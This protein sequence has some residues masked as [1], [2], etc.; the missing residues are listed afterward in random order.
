MPYDETRRVLLCDVLEGGRGRRFSLDEKADDGG[1][2]D[3][4]LN[5]IAPDLTIIAT[6]R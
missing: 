1:D 4:H 2:V 3:K 5:S 6:R